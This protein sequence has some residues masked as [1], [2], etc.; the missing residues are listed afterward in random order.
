MVC[1]Q[2]LPGYLRPFWHHDSNK[3]TGIGW[4]KKRPEHYTRLGHDDWICGLCECGGGGSH[5]N[6]LRHLKK[7]YQHAVEVGDPRARDD[8]SDEAVD[9]GASTGDTAA[10]VAVDQP[11]EPSREAKQPV[12]PPTFMVVR[13]C[14]R[15][16]PKQPVV[17]PPDHILRGEV[18]CSLSSRWCSLSSSRP[19]KVPKQSGGAVRGSGREVNSLEGAVAAIGGRG[20]GREVNSLEGAVAAIAAPLAQDVV[21][22]RRAGRPATEA[23]AEAQVA[24][25]SPSQV[26]Q[27]QVAA[28]SRRGQFKSPSQVAP[29]QVAQDTAVQDASDVAAQQRDGSDKDDGGK[30]PAYQEDNKDGWQKGGSWDKSQTWDDNASAP[31]TWEDNKGGWEKDGR[32]DKS[33]TCDAQQWQEQ[34]RNWDIQTWQAQPWQAQPWQVQPWQ[35]SGPWQSGPSPGGAPPRGPCSHPVHVPLMSLSQELFHDL[36]SGGLFVRE[37]VERTQPFS[38]Q[39]SDQQ[40]WSSGSG[41]QQGGWAP[42][43]GLMSIGFGDWQAPRR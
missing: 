33:Q 37:K 13:N 18:R 14:P 27:A 40:S 3:A 15:K 2:E 39:G 10:G 30:R 20:S 25:S 24:Q 43:G 28:A 21:T 31:Q 8:A 5:L 38:Q 42:A 19:R 9:Q 11:Q 35:D 41:Q 22:C 26:A 23:Q 34:D 6:S 4:D 16:V 32:W 1:F 12:V 7:C 29:S 17:Q 36:M